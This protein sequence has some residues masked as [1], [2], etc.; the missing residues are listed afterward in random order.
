MILAATI[1]KLATY[2]YLRVLIK[3]LPDAT[4]YFNSLVQTIAIIAII[5]TSFLTQQNTKRFIA[6]SSIAN[7]LAYMGVVVLGWL[8]KTIQGI[9]GGILLVLAHSFVS[10][11]LF[12]CVGGIIYDRTE[13]I[14][15]NYIRGL[16]TYIILIAMYLQ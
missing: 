5:Y 7:V 8:T 15:I 1:L 6:Y 10:P 3:N 4:N 16:A 12:I 9:E 13:E 14:I 11:A 2:G